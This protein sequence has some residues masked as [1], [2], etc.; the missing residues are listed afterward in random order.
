MVKHDFEMYFHR[1]IAFP[2][3][4]F[5]ILCTWDDVWSMAKLKHLT[6]MNVYLLQALVVAPS[7][8]VI[9]NVTRGPLNF[10]EILAFILRGDT[11]IYGNLSGIIIF[12]HFKYWKISQPHLEAIG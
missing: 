1:K 4:F 3:E 5:F 8:W 9:A 2:W 12:D 11:N 7:D 10:L 6:L